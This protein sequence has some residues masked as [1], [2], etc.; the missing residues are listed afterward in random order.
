M[1]GGCQ[2]SNTPHI[3]TEAGEE[4]GVPGEEGNGQH[5]GTTEGAKQREG[6]SEQGTTA[7]GRT[8]RPPDCF[9]A[10]VRHL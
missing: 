2:Q 8:D 10:D 6:P 9:V 7:D 1:Q 3:S 4:H 5:D